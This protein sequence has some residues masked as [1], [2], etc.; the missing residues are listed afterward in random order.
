MPYPFAEQHKPAVYYTANNPLS[1]LFRFAERFRRYG[2]PSE[3]RTH[4]YPLG[5]GY[6]IHLTM[7]AY[8]NSSILYYTL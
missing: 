2:T 7:E 4:N 8:K 6:Y 5:G 3:N 1:V